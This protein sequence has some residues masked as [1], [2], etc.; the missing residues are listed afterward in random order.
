MG[1]ILLVRDSNLKPLPAQHCKKIFK[2]DDGILMLVVLPYQSVRGQHACQWKR[3]LGVRLTHDIED[4]IQGLE[5]HALATT[6]LANDGH[7]GA[8]TGARF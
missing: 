2:K 8:A 1:D 5:H 3:T 7:I 6:W 4:L